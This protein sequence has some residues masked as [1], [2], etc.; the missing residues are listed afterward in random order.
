VPLE[1]NE[2][3]H[4]VIESQ[5]AKT[6][7]APAISAWDGTK[8]YAELDSYASILAADLVR[9]GVGPGMFVPLCL[10]KSQWVP[11]AVL[12]VLKAGGAFLLLDPSLPVTRLRENCRLVE[13]S[14]VITSPIDV[15]IAK[16]LAASHLEIGSE[17]TLWQQE[18]LSL[19]LNSRHPW[20]QIIP[21]ESPAFVVFTSGSTGAPKGI[22]TEHGACASS[23]A[24]QAGPLRLHSKSR[25]F[26]FSS[27]AFDVATNDILLTLSMGACLCIPSEDDRVNRLAETARDMGVTWIWASPSVCRL[28]HPK[29]IPSL[30]TLVVGGELIT[31]DDISVWSRKLVVVYGLAECGIVSTVRSCVT[32]EKGTSNIGKAVSSTGTWIVDPR[33]PH[34]LVPV[35]VAGELVLEGPTVGCRYIGRQI[36][37]HQQSS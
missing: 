16:D 6:P 28:I 30:E 10:S 11:V 37:N 21:A 24:A 17:C 32:L 18:N 22:A 12:A 15:G 19:P 2:C 34:Q 25:V 4:T 8:N 1:F 31:T 29:D 20:S 36:Q 35:G 14:L 27:H 23:L 13:A 33:D 9:R 7:Y 3:V 26:Q 5:E